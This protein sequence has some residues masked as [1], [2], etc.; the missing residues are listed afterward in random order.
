MRACTRTWFFLLSLFWIAGHA[1][2]A[3]EPSTWPEFSPAKAGFSIRLPAAPAEQVDPSTGSTNFQVSDGDKLY[4][5]SFAN[6]PREV[7]QQMSP[8]QILDKTRAGILRS[9]PGSS[10]VKSENL[11]YGGFPATIFVIESQTPGQPD[12][13][14]KTMA[15]VAGSRLFSAGFMSRK[16]VFVEADVDKYL[17]TLKIK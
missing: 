5:A 1:A 8:Q 10:I 13:K 6:L 11:N 9:L 15:I 4:V 17:A 3:G 7:L 14:L 2:I 16:D 12:T